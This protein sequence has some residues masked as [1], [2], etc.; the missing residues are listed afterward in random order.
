ALWK[1]DLPSPASVAGR[2]SLGLLDALE[3]RSRGRSAAEAS[4]VKARQI[5]VQSLIARCRIALARI[6]LKERVFPEALEL[7]TV[8][9]GDEVLGPEML[10]ELHFWHG[11]ALKATGDLEGARK[12][13]V[14]C[15]HLIDSISTRLPP[16]D[17]SGFMARPDIRVF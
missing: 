2:A 1:N 11:E 4:L 13:R 7:T 8:K 9:K 15:R 10:A 17:R 14:L 16:E 5:G 3:G 6:D 12:E